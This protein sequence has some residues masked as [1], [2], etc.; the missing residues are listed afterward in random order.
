MHDSYSLDMQTMHKN[1][2]TLVAVK[3]FENRRKIA[4]LEC[5]WWIPSDRSGRYGQAEL[6]VEQN[7][8]LLPCAA[9]AG[10]RPAAP[11]SGEVAVTTTKPWSTEACCWH[12]RSTCAEA[13]THVLNTPI[14]PPLV[15]KLHLLHLCVEIDKGNELK[16]QK[17]K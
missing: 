3:R 10:P 15:K 5:W 11:M 9:I 14:C 12:T 16:Q 7:I 1:L 2:A 4:N 17:D 6:G 13:T 8:R